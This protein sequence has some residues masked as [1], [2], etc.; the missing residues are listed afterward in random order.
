FTPVMGL[1]SGALQ[2]MLV[3]VRDP[4]VCIGVWSGPGVALWIAVSR[5]GAFA[6]IPNGVASASNVVRLLGFHR[7]MVLLYGLPNRNLFSLVLY[8][9]GS[10][11]YR[12]TPFMPGS[13]PSGLRP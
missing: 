5:R 6:S 3:I 9:S 2:G 7:S 1:V 4:G 8:P 12:V 13:V 11:T 10:L